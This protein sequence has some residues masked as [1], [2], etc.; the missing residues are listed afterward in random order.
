MSRCSFDTMYVGNLKGVGKIWQYT[1]VDGACS[2][3]FARVFAGEKSAA[4]A[5]T[6]LA[7][8]V[9]PVYAGGLPPLAE[10]VVDGGPEFK[11]GSPPRA[12]R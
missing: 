2:F 1:A 6:F 9:A 3:A 5:A 8:D 11:R 7:N 4:R 12:A 10:A